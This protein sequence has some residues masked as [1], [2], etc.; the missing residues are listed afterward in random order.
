[1]PFPLQ[2]TRRTRRIAGREDALEPRS[3]I[4]SSVLLHTLLVARVRHTPC[5]SPGSGT[6]PVGRP[7]QAHALLVPRV[8]HTPC[9]PPGSGTCPVVRPGQVLALL[10]SGVGIH[11]NFFSPC[12]VRGRHSLQPF[13]SLLWPGAGIHFNYFW[14]WQHESPNVLQIRSFYIKTLL[15]ANRGLWM[16]DKILQI[17]RTKLIKRTGAGMAPSET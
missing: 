17:E 5:R 2:P 16:L 15:Y 4:S 12:C 13:F 7:G 8:R 9:C 11:F 3:G 14:S 1:M 6:R 10:W